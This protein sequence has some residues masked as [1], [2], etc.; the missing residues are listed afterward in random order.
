MVGRLLLLARGQVRVRVTG[1]SL[2]RFLNACARHGITPVSYTH[3]VWYGKSCPALRLPFLL[4]ILLWNQNRQK[5][6]V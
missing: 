1:A 5:R 4:P 6:L 3:L 2:P